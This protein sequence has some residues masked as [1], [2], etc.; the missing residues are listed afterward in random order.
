[1][2]LLTESGY[3]LV[4]D[5]RAIASSPD[6]EA[7]LAARRLLRP[8]EALVMAGQPHLVGALPPLPRVR[9]VS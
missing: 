2:I 6:L 3:D 7:I 5:E 9:E 4:D 8:N 1:M